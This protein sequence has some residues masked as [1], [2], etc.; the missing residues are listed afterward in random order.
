MINFVLTCV[1]HGKRFITSVPD[2]P[3]PVINDISPFHGGLISQKLASAKYLENE[4]LAKISDFTVERGSV[5][6]NLALNACTHRP[7][8]NAYVVYLMNEGLWIRATP[9]PLR[10]VL[11]PDTLSCA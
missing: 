2:L 5:N 9:E 3:T 8:I 10:C 11:E 7:T 1:E 6:D 4:T